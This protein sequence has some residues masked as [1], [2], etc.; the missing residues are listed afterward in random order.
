M[1]DPS[2]HTAC[3]L[4]MLVCGVM[5]HH[6]YCHSRVAPYLLPPLSK[7]LSL[8]LHYRA[9]VEFIHQNRR[10]QQKKS[11]HEA[12]P[13]KQKS[14]KISE[15]R[16]DAIVTLL[17]SVSIIRQVMY[18]CMYTLLSYGRFREEESDSHLPFDVLIFL[19]T[20]LI[21]FPTKLQP[22]IEIPAIFPL[23]THEQTEGHAEAVRQAG[24]QAVSHKSRDLEINYLLLYDAGWWLFDGVCFHLNADSKFSLSLFFHRLFVFPRLLNNIIP[25][26]ILSLAHWT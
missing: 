22:A 26:L 13:G 2:S 25:G 3:F 20:N 10:R 8:V 19:S 4:Q 1:P 9:G 7:S 15:V 11:R 6:L 12:K 5:R 17:L 23:L 18:H 16:P 21:P 14:H 24:R